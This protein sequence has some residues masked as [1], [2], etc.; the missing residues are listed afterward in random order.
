MSDFDFVQGQ[1]TD[2]RALL[3]RVADAVG[4]VPNRVR[5]KAAFPVTPASDS[6]PPPPGAR[7]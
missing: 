1:Y 6:R 2:Q 3:K 5:A 4:P 7:S